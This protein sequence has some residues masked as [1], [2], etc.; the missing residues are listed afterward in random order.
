MDIKKG[1][2]ANKRK[3]YKGKCPECFGNIS[4]MGGIIDLD[5]D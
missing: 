3:I 2:T 5:N 1:K 4:R